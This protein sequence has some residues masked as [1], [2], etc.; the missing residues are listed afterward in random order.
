M[1]ATLKLLPMMSLA[2]TVKLAWTTRAGLRMVS[3]CQ[4]LELQRYRESEYCVPQIVGDVVLIV[5]TRVLDF[6]ILD[7]I[8]YPY[9]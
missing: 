6:S 1:D 3:P 8:L 7:S 4:L 2:D 5:C 9:K